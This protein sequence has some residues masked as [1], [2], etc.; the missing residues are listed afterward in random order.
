MSK[1]TN[2]EFKIFEGIYPPSE[3]TMLL[4]DCVREYPPSALEVCCGAGLV[5]LKLAKGGTKVI[6][7]DLDLR[8]CNNTLH[9]AKINNLHHLVNV[10][11]TDLC[12][13]IRGKFDAIYC[14]PPYLPFD[15]DIRESLWWYGGKGGVEK[16]LRIVKEASSI[17][18]EDG[19]LFLVFS[20]LSDIANIQS[21]LKAND[22]VYDL[23]SSIKFGPEEIFVIKAKLVGK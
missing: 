15:D 19:S 2:F 21:S 13:G 18:K 7:S 4:L 6:A 14:N 9:N 5:S 8:A 12:S 10:V 22:F 11:R 20:S 23:V 3:D 17:L 1:E 16:I